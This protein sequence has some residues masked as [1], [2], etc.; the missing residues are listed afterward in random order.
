MN[1]KL[2]LL[3][4]TVALFLGC[5][6][7]NKPTLVTANKDEDKVTSGSDLIEA[8][9]SVTLDQGWSKDEELDFYNTS[10]GSQL[11]PYYWFL[12]LEQANNNDLFRDNKN[13]RYLGY[14]PQAPI[15]DRNPEGLPIGFVKDDIQEDFL[16]SALNATRLSSGSQMSQ[17]SY[18]EWLGLTCAA[19]HTSEI[20]YGGKTLRINGGSAQSDFPTF[21]DNLSK[22]LA[23]TANED[24]KLTRFAKKV[25][26]EG[27]YN[28]T[29]KQA[30]KTQLAAYIDWL[31]GYIDINYGKLRTP[32]GYGR[33]DA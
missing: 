22:A 5:S 27:G 29:E 14:I 9:K 2:W 24:A 28:E 15:P 4:C 19:C 32:Y 1:T 23:A 17:T 12:A 16:V 10:Q 25:L 21:L 11:L 13:I 3:I 18:K 8:N 26:A 7:E 33:L 6:E 20:D 30:L 31:N